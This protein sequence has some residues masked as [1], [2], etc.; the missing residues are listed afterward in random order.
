MIA[1]VAEALEEEEPDIY[2]QE[3][4]LSLDSWLLPPDAIEVLE[5][6]TLLELD[7]TLN[8]LGGH[9]ELPS[10]APLFQGYFNRIKAEGDRAQFHLTEANLR[11]VVSVAK[12]YL[13]RGMPLLDM[14]QEGNIGLIR[15]VEKFNYREG[16]KFSTC[17]HWSIR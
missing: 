1:N 13:G 16:F 12:K 15:A 8:K 17:A 2:R 5:D 4:N 7:A 3:V 14:I 9:P 10:L 11:L 6:C